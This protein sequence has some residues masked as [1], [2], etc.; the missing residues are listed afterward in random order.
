MFHYEIHINFGDE[1]N[2][3]EKI[4]LNLSAIFS[5]TPDNGSS[6]VQILNIINQSFTE[7]GMTK[8]LL[9]NLQTN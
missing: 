5:T 1:Q 6:H 3:E 4:L 7:N 2:V 8:T 9:R